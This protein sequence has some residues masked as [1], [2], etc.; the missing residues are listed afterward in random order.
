MIINFHL[1]DLPEEVAGVAGYLDVFKVVEGV[2]HPAMGWNEL[3]K[4]LSDILLDFEEGS[5]RAAELLLKLGGS[6]VRDA[7]LVSV[8]PQNLLEKEGLVNR[9]GKYLIPISAGE[10]CRMLSK[11][12][13]IKAITGKGRLVELES[14][15]GFYELRNRCRYMRPCRDP[16]VVYVAK[17]LSE[18]QTLNSVEAFVTKLN[19]MEGVGL[20]HR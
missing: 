8:I 18:V 2:S 19:Y 10:F 4:Y 16:S 12:M 17:A 11:G 15:I 13:I 9:L 1:P 20:E 3:S 14:L 5:R 6:F 7:S